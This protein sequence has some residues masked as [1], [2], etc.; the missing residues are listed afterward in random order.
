RVR[1]VW[2]SQNEAEDKRGRRHCCW[3]HSRQHYLHGHLL[4]RITNCALYLEIP[5]FSIF[6]LFV[7]EFRSE[8]DDSANRVRSRGYTDPGSNEQL[9]SFPNTPNDQAG[10]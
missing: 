10:S 7:T 2:E 3:N 1:R 9:R 4:V 5:S 8:L 6:R